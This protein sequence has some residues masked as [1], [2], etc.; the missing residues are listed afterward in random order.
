MIDN[1]VHPSIPEGSSDP[2]AL[3]SDSVGQEVDGVGLLCLVD[4]ATLPF[5]WRDVDQ[6]VID[7]TFLSSIPEGS[8]VK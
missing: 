6:G 4:Y 8:C 1:H 2:G 5:F 7:N 3:V